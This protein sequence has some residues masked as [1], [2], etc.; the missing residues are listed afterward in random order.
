MSVSTEWVW[1]FTDQHYSKNTGQHLC[2]PTEHLRSVGWTLS[3]ESFRAA[4]Q[5]RP[6]RPGSAGEQTRIMDQDLEEFSLVVV[7]ECKKGENHAVF[8]VFLLLSAHLWPLTCCPPAM[9]S[10]A[11]TLRLIRDLFPSSSRGFWEVRSINGG[12]VPQDV[13]WVL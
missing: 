1:S 13:L 3:C 8:T 10:P 6:D 7:S 4:T 5:T 12:W 9:L 2:W 11:Q